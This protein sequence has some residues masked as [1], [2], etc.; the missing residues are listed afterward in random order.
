MAKKKR[1]YTKVSCHGTK[2]AAK[3]AQ[4]KLQAKGMTASVRKD[5]KTGKHCIY[6]A[7]KKRR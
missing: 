3:K 1:K 4:K 2:T 7:G 6:S 5:S